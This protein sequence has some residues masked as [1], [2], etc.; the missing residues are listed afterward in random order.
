MIARGDLL[1][2]SKEVIK[3]FYQ[4]KVSETIAI[5]RRYISRKNAA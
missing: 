4:A 2:L 1:R 5:I 3:P